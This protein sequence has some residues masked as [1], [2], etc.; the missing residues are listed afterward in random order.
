VEF[1]ALLQ[2]VTD[3]P[4]NSVDT[5]IKYEKIQRAASIFFLLNL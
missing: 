5:G 2:A 1:K 4:Y 3:D